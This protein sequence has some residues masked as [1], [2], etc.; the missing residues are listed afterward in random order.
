MMEKEKPFFSIV[1]PTYNHGHL[2]KRC[3]DSIVAQT[4]I[5][6][7]A[8]VVN[9]YSNDNTVEIVES[10]RDPRIRLVNNANHGIIAVSRNKGIELAKGDWICFLD[11]DD[12]WTCNKLEA[13]IPFLTNYDLIYTDMFI[14]YNAENH[15]LK[16]LRGYQV[17]KRDPYKEM[18]LRGNPC[19]NSSVVCRKSV[20]EKIG[21]LS[22]DVNLIAVEDFDYWLRMAWAKVRFKHIKKCLGYYWLGNGNL[23]FNKKQVNRMEALYEKHLMNIQSSKLKQEIIAHLCYRQARIFQLLKEYDASI[24]K[25]RQSFHCHD[26]SVVLRSLLFYSLILLKRKYE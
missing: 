15:G 19:V 20:I 18:L 2:I 25:F 24:E 17:N 5:H 8:I 4:Y 7:E 11:S 26:F 22:A 13:C 12:W 6:W 3:L 14:R 1:I 21:Y 10:Y 16:T 9:N 23:S